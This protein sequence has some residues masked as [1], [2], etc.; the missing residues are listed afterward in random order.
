M[1]DEGQSDK[2]YILPSI[3]GVFLLISETMPFIKRL[4]S[5]GIIHFFFNETRR[6]LEFE[7]R[8]PLLDNNIF[9]DV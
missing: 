9:D 7:R 1:D 4:D 8:E 6:F 2:Y 5:N 3:F